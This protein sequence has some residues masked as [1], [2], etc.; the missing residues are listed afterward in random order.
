MK[1]LIAGGLISIS[2]MFVGCA[3]I[4]FAD[5]VQDAK[6]WATG[7]N[8]LW[9]DA[10]TTKTA[11]EVKADLIAGGVSESTAAAIVFWLPVEKGVVAI[12]PD[13]VTSID[14]LVKAAL[15]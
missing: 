7:A 15:K 9:T 6:G 11:A 2:L 4:N 3:G 5:V 10:N 13:L 14:A 1:K 8:V 12:T